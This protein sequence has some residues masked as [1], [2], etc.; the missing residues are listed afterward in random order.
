MEAES[1]QDAVDRGDG[2]RRTVAACGDLNGAPSRGEKDRVRCAEARR[3]SGGAASGDARWDA[4]DWRREQVEGRR[5][6]P[7]LLAAAPACR[8]YGRVEAIGARG[9]VYSWC[10]AGQPNVLRGGENARCAV[11][12]R[13]LHP[14]RGAAPDK[15]VFGV[16]ARANGAPALGVDR[17]RRGQVRQAKQARV[18]QRVG[19]RVQVVVLGA[20]TE[21][22]RRNVALP[23][24]RVAH[25]HHKPGA[26]FG[27]PLGRARLRRAARREP[28]RRAVVR[29]ARHLT[30]AVRVGALPALCS[31]FHKA[32]R[33]FG[34]SAGLER[35]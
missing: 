17:R 22:G 15:R 1:F 35:P 20:V 18:V 23:R 32:Q 10:C 14:I 5:R 9:G 25:A 34:D 12:P 30:E 29:A 16:V 28:T 13:A 2:W 11:G 21:A 4:V 7:H 24:R 3:G 26:A 27:E 8:E 33:S 19:E 31:A 6:L